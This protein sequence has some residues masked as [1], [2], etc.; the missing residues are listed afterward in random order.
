MCTLGGVNI[1]SEIEIK[2]VLNQKLDALLNSEESIIY[3]ILTGM[4]LDSSLKFHKKQFVPIL[5]ITTG[6]KFEDKLAY[7]KN[8]K[9]KKDENN[10][11][12]NSE[13]NEDGSPARRRDDSDDEYGS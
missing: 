2:L 4:T 9:G 6:K 10:D 3:N 12:S 7:F 11:S 13:V 5:E 1:E 8:K